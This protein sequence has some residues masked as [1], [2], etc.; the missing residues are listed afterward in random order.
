MA[1]L[2][3]QYEWSVDVINTLN[4]IGSEVNYSA[5]R[6]GSLIESL[7]EGGYPKEMLD[8]LILMNVD[9]QREV[10]QLKIMIMDDH[11]EYMNNQRQAI[12]DAMD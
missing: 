8:Q 11:A 2:Q 4:T 7:A 5:N 3:E 6:Y 12:A 9:F 1:S 10:D